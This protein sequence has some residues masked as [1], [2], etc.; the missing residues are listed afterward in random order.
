MRDF[1]SLRTLEKLLHT[2]DVPWNRRKDL[3]PT[4]LRWLEK[5][6]SVRNSAH[7]EYPQAIVLIE[8]LIQDG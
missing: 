3:N 8:K 1:E 6:L 4:K 5:N 2:M 7:K